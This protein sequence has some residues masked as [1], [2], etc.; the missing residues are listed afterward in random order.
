[1]RPAR[2][3]QVLLNRAEHRF[4]RLRAIV[5]AASAAIQNRESRIALAYA[6][7]EA[8]NA[9]S[10]FARSY[11]L[12]C[13]LRPRRVRGGI[14]SVT[15]S[16]STFSAAIGL[17]MKTHKPKLSPSAAGAFPRKLEPSWYEPRILRLSCDALG[18]SH[19][20]DIQTALA[21]PTRAIDH[22]TIYRHFFAHRNDDTCRA[23]QAIAPA[24]SI[25]SNLHPVR[26]LAYRPIGRPYPLLADWL[27]DILS[28]VRLL[29]D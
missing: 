5:I 29:C 13:V 24:Y 9:W 18:C 2:S 25:P 15:L 28:I 4:G 21:V 26:I 6:A 20:S 19:K 27:D 16:V 11:Y 23:A 14:V 10:S 7:I 1:M 8:H 22:L 3:F 17:A 12:S